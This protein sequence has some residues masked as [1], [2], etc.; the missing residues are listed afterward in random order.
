M[1]VVRI[2]GPA[3]SYHVSSVLQVF[4]PLILRCGVGR[5]RIFAY[6]DIRWAKPVEKISGVPLHDVGSLLADKK[7]FAKLVAPHEGLGRTEAA[8]KIQDFA[9]L[10]RAIVRDHR[11]DR[12]GFDGLIIDDAVA[13]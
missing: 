8:K 9:I 7:P 3:D 5:N 13:V 11:T 10:E 12:D 4:S 1:N 6:Q 2:L